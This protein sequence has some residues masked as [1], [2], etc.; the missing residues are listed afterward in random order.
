LKPAASAAAT[1]SPTEGTIPVGTQAV[2]KNET[3]MTPQSLT[4]RYMRFLTILMKINWQSGQNTQRQRHQ[5]QTSLQV[6]ET[7]LAK[8]SSKSPGVRVGLKKGD[9]GLSK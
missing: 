2:A 7:L 8:K 1:C 5:S 4:S 9:H 6:M 3:A